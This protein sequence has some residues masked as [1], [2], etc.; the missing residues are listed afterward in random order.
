MSSVN[1]LRTIERM[2]AQGLNDV[3]EMLERRNLLWKFKYAT[4]TETTARDEVV[5]GRYD[6]ATAMIPMIA[7]TGPLAVGD[8]VAVIYVP[9]GGNYVI[10]V[11][12]PRYPATWQNYTPVVQGATSGGA[13]GNGTM[14]AR[15]L[16]DHRTST[17]DININLI[18]GSTT[19]FGV[20]TLFIGLPT[21]AA[22]VSF[23]HIGD[24]FLID[25]SPTGRII[26]TCELDNVD[27]FLLVTTAG[28]IVNSTAPWTWTTNDQFRVNARYEAR[29]LP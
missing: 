20:G 5:F 12:Q 10:G 18:F 27:R 2:V 6:G 26:G 22:N 24:C 23:P 15:W 8:R 4:I 16:Y 3:P 13:I 9:P 21:S 1:Y 11:V 17:V 7:L 14:N 25:A 28:A 19:S 29:R